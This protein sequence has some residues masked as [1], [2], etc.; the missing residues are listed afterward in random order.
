MKIEVQAP[1]SQFKELRLRGYIDRGCKYVH[2]QAA[3]HVGGSITARPIPLANFRGR[4]NNA[5]NALADCGIVLFAQELSELLEHVIG[6]TD[7]KPRSI[8]AYPGWYDGAYVM[9]D[10]GIVK[11]DSASSPIAVFDYVP[12]KVESSGDHAAWLAEVAEEYAGHTLAEFVMMLPF[13][14]PVLSFSESPFNFGIEL[15]DAP[16]TG[17]TTLLKSAASIVG[18]VQGTD[19]AAVTSMNATL[20]AIDERMPFNR[21]QPLFLEEW[22]LLTL[23]SGA[24]GGRDTAELIFRLSDG[25]TKSRHKSRD[26]PRADLVW[27]TTTNEPWRALAHSLPIDVARAA[28]DRMMTIEGSK[29][30]YSGF[31][32]KAQLNGEGLSAFCAR[33]SR[34]TAQHYGTAMRC[35]VEHLCGLIERSGEVAITDYMRTQGKAFCEYAKRRNIA[36]EER[37]LGSVGLIY[38]AGKL[39]IQSGALPSSYRPLRAAASALLR[40]DRSRRGI[41]TPF[42]L[43]SGLRHDRNAIDLRDDPPLTYAD[44]TRASCLLHGGKSSGELL[45]TNGQMARLNLPKKDI[46]GDARVKAAMICEDGRLQVYRAFWPGRRERVYCF[47]LAKL[48]D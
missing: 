48:A 8:S 19:A 43:L 47:E 39:A 40:I 14:A 4:A 18:P 35:Y 25:K 28:A 41:V 24:N 12:G 32:R 5:A 33:L 37:V 15:C 46:L 23:T 2:I 1:N 16:A 3:Q 44:I 42:E 13:A 38:A 26:V 27:L 31:L 34:A 30:G 45:L 17:K 6:Y 11:G 21:D 22:N 29:K 36:A 9:P 7:Y 10:G 20:N